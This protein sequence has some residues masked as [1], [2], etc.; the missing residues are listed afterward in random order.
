MVRD[1]F[2]D[3]EYTIVVPAEADIGRQRRRIRHWE[4]PSPG[5]ALASQ[6]RSTVQGIQVDG[7]GIHGADDDI[8]LFGAGLGHRLCG[9]PQVNDAGGH[10]GAGISQSPPTRPERACLGL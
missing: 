4:P 2:G 1:D 9:T 3:S 5:I 6:A 7:Y 10:G 8:G